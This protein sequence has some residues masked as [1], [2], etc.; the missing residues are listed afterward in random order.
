[1]NYSDLNSFIKPAIEILILW[2]L[3][4]R[5][6]L[7]LTGTRAVKVLIGIA[8]LILTFLAAQLFNLTVVEWLF[9]KL[10]GISVIALLVIFSPEIR[11]GLA[12]L[13]Q[14]HLFSPPLKDEELDQVLHQDRKSVV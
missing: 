2:L 8:V 6:I 9:T 7:F 14:R 3:I 11:Q 4:Y 5:A 13:G 1:M 12:Q 10:F